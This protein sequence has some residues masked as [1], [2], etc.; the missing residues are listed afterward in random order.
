MSTQK[1]RA[2]TKKRPANHTSD[3]RMS[4][5]QPTR[6]FADDSQPRKRARR[7][8]ASD[9]PESTFKNPFGPRSNVPLTS[10]VNESTPLPPNTYTQAS[11]DQITYGYTPDVPPDQI[12]SAYI[13][14]SSTSLS[15]TPF[16]STSQATSFIPP[17]PHDLSPASSDFGPIDPGLD[18]AAADLFTTTKST[19]SSRSN[20][21]LPSFSGST[22]N[23][24]LTAFPSLSSARI[25]AKAQQPTPPV[26]IPAVDQIP[27]IEQIPPRIPKVITDS[28]RSHDTRISDLESLYNQVESMVLT[29]KNE[30]HLRINDIIHAQADIMR[31]IDNEQTNAEQRIGVLE[32]QVK[33]QGKL[34]E[35]LLKMVANGG[36]KGELDVEENDSKPKGNRDNAFNTAVRRCIFLAMGLPQ[37]AKLR[38]AAAVRPGKSGGGYIQDPE[39]SGKLLRPDWRVPFTENSRWHDSMIKLVRTKAPTVVPALKKS[40]I[41]AK[42][43]EHILERLDVVFKNITSAYRKATKPVADADGSEPEEGN[44]E[45]ANRRRSRKARKCEER[46]AAIDEYDIAIPDEWT[47]FLQAVY[48]S[49][50][51]SDDAEVLDPDTD[52]EATDEVPAAST[53]KPWI[54]HPPLYRSEVFDEGVQVIDS[55]LMKRRVEHARNNKGKTTGYP[56]IRAEKKDTPLPFI[57]SKKAIRI[58]RDAIDP[59]WLSTHP[60]QDTPSRIYQ[61]EDEEEVEVEVENEVE[62]E[63]L[64]TEMG[65]NE[66]LDD[67]EG[68][69]SDE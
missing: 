46:K 12:T 49:T 42:S 24:P 9:T 25:P 67:M 34:I 40:Q 23:S 22:S 13:N 64:E 69:S 37:T 62:V 66:E 63:S 68:E 57:S 28:L 11:P 56:R 59:E 41:Q 10:S 2:G 33:K 55:A 47:W 31:D 6:A 53:R 48:Q 58:C 65:E 45:Q 51:E 1:P 54:T 43:D 7:T 5:K 36:S 15:E 29:T 60:S 8:P 61:S 16:A 35:G 26:Q 27:A 3:T 39:S 44:E 14:K 21:F 18:A 50:D 19:V 30:Q 52:T 38:D 17:F 4:E 20:L 32:E